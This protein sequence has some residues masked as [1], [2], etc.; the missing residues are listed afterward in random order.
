MTLILASFVVLAVFVNG[1]Y[2][3]AFYLVNRETPVV[4]NDQSETLDMMV[5]AGIK[6]APV[7]GFLALVVLLVGVDGMV[8]EITKKTKS[9]APRRRRS[10]FSIDS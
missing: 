7:L 9:T 1:I 6:M 4:P 8:K 2:S 5:T 10:T 3:I